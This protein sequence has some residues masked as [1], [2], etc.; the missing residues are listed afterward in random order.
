[1]SNWW[2]S[3]KKKK[4]SLKRVWTPPFLWPRELHTLPTV[5][6]GTNRLTASAKPL[7]FPLVS[8]QVSQPSYV[9]SPWKFLFLFKLLAICLPRNSN[10][11]NSFK[12][13]HEFAIFPAFISFTVKVGTMLF[14]A[15]YILEQTLEMLWPCS[16]LFICFTVYYI[17]YP[18]QLNLF[19]K[20][21]LKYSQ[22]KLSLSL[23]DKLF[24]PFS[25]L[26]QYILHS[27]PLNKCIEH[28]HC[29]TDAMTPKEF[30][31]SKSAQIMQ[32]KN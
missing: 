19:F 32:G 27:I 1:M 16:F 12:T 28:W 17:L 30:H 4:K 23:Q 15:L 6:L 2:G 10:L 25:V 29:S 13:T 26:L 11:S 7:S 18:K 14:L 9:I 22:L 20:F 31:S 3:W 21:Q 8:L 5:H 24:T